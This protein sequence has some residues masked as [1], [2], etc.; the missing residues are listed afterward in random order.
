MI[1]GLYILTNHDNT[2]TEVLLSQV[3]QALLGGANMVQYRDKTRDTAK[4][5]QQA[6]ALL[7]L[8]HRYHK[9]LIINDSIALAQAVNADGV[10]LGKTDNSLTK[11]RQLLGKQKII[12][13][14]CYNS[15]DLA[16]TAQQQGANYIAFGRFYPSQTKPHA[17]PAPLSLLT[18][19]KPTIDLPMVA[20]GGI[21]KTNAKVLVDAGA[22]SL[23]V[24]QSIWQRN[25]I[26][27]EARA[28]A[29][30]FKQNR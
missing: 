27:A 2:T 26:Q 20:I 16:I 22:D 25:D 6:T 18:Q 28:T 29:S 4:Q 14:S 3:E 30:L 11:A 9:P 15:L 13:I 7:K 5:Y 24:I 21:N 23:A 19:A 1:Y 8:C 10:H 17:I 12:G